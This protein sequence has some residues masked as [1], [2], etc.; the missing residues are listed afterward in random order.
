MRTDMSCDMAQGL[1]FAP[2]MECEEFK[3]WVASV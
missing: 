3:Q 2:S 1:I